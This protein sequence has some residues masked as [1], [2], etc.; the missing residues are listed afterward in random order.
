M[1]A[2]R[3]SSMLQKCDDQTFLTNDQNDLHTSTWS[4]ILDNKPISEGTWDQSEGVAYASGLSPFGPSS[5][6]RDVPLN[7]GAPDSL[8]E[9]FFATNQDA[10]P[11]NLLLSPTQELDIQLG[12]F[13][14]SSS[15]S[16]SADP[17]PV[18]E[19]IPR[20]ASTPCCASVSY[21]PVA[22]YEHQVSEYAQDYGTVHP[23]TAAIQEPTLD[24]NTATVPIGEMMVD[25]ATARL[26]LGRYNVGT[27]SSLVHHH[28]STIPHYV[29][30][31]ENAAPLDF[32]L[33]GRVGRHPMASSSVASSI[34]VARA[35]R[36]RTRFL[37]GVCDVG[38]VQ[39]QG[40]NRHNGDKHQPR[41]ICPHCGVFKWSPARHYLFTRHFKR[42]HP[43]VPL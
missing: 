8:P 36:N 2:L 1:S 25:P 29:H 15:C 37:C 5:N 31:N 6:G 28:S 23:S 18:L 21:G 38:F 26:A 34:R 16:P 43:G 14:Q 17:T 3:D 30:R 12:N 4:S 13:L 9:S 42:D 11:W 32:I 40:L 22:E 39:R 7:T 24:T 19:L 10:P 41:N 20:M 27:T 35:G 33:A